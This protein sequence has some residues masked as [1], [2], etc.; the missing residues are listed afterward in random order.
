MDRTGV[1]LE[2]EGWL[3]GEGKQPGSSQASSRVLAGGGVAR[4]VRRRGAPGMIA[5]VLVFFSLA[6]AGAAPPAATAPAEA[7]PEGPADAKTE[8][9]AA[10]ALGFLC[11]L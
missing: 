5:H 3:E 10:Q 8:A 4:T 2:G 11:L 6:L 9:Q 7:T 1:S